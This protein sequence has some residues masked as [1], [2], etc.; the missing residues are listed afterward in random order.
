MTYNLNSFTFEEWLKFVFDHPVLD[1]TGPSYN[2]KHWYLRDEEWNLSNWDSVLQ[3]EFCTALF[4]EPSVI[5]TKY[6]WE[7]IEEGFWFLLNEIVQYL[8]HDINIPWIK[9]K[10]LIESM[11]NL[12]ERLF[13]DDP[14]TLT[15][16]M[17]W[18]GLCYDYFMKKG[19]VENEDDLNVQNTALET[20]K[21]ILKI[22]SLK[23]Q[24]AALHGL[25]HVMH[26]ETASVINEFLE[27]HA[28]LPK[29]I[30]EYAKCCIQGTM[31]QMGD[32]MFEKGG[33]KSSQ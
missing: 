25:G 33:T 10:K 9:R 30:Q 11:E 7:Q 4:D 23:C 18:D 1:T 14:I 31:D 27:Q 24:V 16:F 12:Y 15:S 2:Q 6:S 26:K 8:I 32:P 5:K 13:S 21:R 28:N 20:L 22:E 3:A 19:V 29:R 17:W